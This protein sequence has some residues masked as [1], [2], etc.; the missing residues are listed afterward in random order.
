MALEYLH[1]KDIIHRD[2]KPE[3][4]IISNDGHFKLTDFGISEVGLLNNKSDI[5][6]ERKFSSEEYSVDPHKILGTENYLA[7]EVIKE[8]HIT[9]E[10]DYWALGVLIY[11]LFTGKMPFGADS[12]SKIFNNIL[13]VNID[14]LVFDSLK[15]KDDSAKDLIKKLLVFNPHLR[16]GSRNVN[17]IKEHYFFDGFDWKNVKNIRDSTVMKH[18]KSRLEEFNKS[19]PK[20]TE[21]SN[22]ND[23]VSNDDDE[24]MDYFCKSVVRN[25]DKK[26]KDIVKSDIKQKKLD[27]GSDEKLIDIMRDII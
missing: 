3:N 5:D 2:L 8:E 22:Q 20:V 1:S 6:L 17:Q 16:W 25:L 26:N 21:N 7:P 27:F 4:I 24:S 15:L 11:E 10:V 23:T 13:N 19:R 14:W 9:K 18:V 12:T